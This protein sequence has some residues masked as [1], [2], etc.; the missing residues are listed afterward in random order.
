MTAS[1]QT[2]DTLSAATS[3]ATV[4]QTSRKPARQS[5][6]LQ[7]AR[8]LHNRLELR[9]PGNV[10]L[11]RHCC[12]PD[13]ILRG[14]HKPRSVSGVNDA[15][16]LHRSRCWLQGCKDSAS[17]IGMDIN[18]HH[19]RLCWGKVVCALRHQLGHHVSPAAMLSGHKADI[20]ACVWA[21]A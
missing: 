21:S 4:T 5:A 9:P 20:A 6:T 7:P 10:N 8:L 14:I 3:P 13:R 12:V 18:E 19:P 1:R 15:E 16:N 2:S 11:L 17:A